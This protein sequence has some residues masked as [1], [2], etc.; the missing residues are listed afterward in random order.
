MVGG[1]VRSW[2]AGMALMLA[3]VGAEARPPHKVVVVH[4]NFPIV[5]PLPRVVVRP[6]RVAV[7]VTVRS[8]LPPLVF[9]PTVVT[10]RPELVIWEDGE[11]LAR[12]EG[13]T[14]FTLGVHGRGQQLVLSVHGG[15]VK[16]NFA[17]VVF[18]NGDAQ[19]VDFRESV[20]RPGTY[21][22]LDVSGRS[23]D[24]LRMVAQAVSGSARLTLALVK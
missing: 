5:R 22:L 10:Y 23:V 15:A 16:V 3:G 17:E 21:A 4:P 6:P 20:V 11:T 1:R 19:V 18:E 13:W 2:A 8:F 12:R 14:E 7:R 24:H 9:V